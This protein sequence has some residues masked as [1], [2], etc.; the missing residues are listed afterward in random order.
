MSSRGNTNVWTQAKRLLSK[1]ASIPAASFSNFIEPLKLEEIGENYY[2]LTAPN[3]AILNGA[4]KKFQATITKAFSEVTKNNYEVRIQLHLE[5]RKANDPYH[6]ANAPILHLKNYMAENYDIMTNEFSGQKLI[7][8]KSE[9]HFSPVTKEFY[10]DLIFSMKQDKRFNSVSREDIGI[11]LDVIGKQK[12]NPIKELLDHY[13]S[14]YVAS[15]DGD[16]FGKYCSYV[17]I[18]N[19]FDFTATMRK[20]IFRTLHQMLDRNFT[21]EHLLVFQGIE[22]LRKSTWITGLFPAWLE[23]FTELGTVDDIGKD[24]IEKLSNK[25]IWFIDE[26]DNINQKLQKQIKLILSLKRDDRRRAY[27][28]FAT[29]FHRITSFITALNSK[30]F[31]WSGRKN[32]RFIIFTVTEL[33]N[34]DRTDKIDKTKMWGQIYQ[35]YKAIQDKKSLYW[36]LEE[37]K[38]FEKNNESYQIENSEVSK[39]LKYFKALDPVKFD[40]SNPKHLFLTSTEIIE[41]LKGIDPEL[42]GKLSNEAVGRFLRNHDF[43]NKMPYRNYYLELAV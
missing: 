29:T 23:P 26:W 1:N 38:A 10:S 25:L 7:K 14:A 39:L 31:L 9:R 40:K 32:R 2:I 21:N 13:E 41:Y 30:H 43:V 3:Q 34:T 28:E 24:F 22:G 37:Q 11:V 42:S 36:T 20:W 18:N 5:K 6:D 35:E 19:G 27:A 17:R 16:L 12:L 8:M 4:L 33:I 15:R